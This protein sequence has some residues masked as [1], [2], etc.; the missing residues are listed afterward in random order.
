MA[1]GGLGDLEGGGAE[2]R[3]LF[4][5]DNHGDDEVTV[6]HLEKVAGV[7]GGL[8][9]FGKK[10]GVVGGDAERDSRADVA[11]DGVAD[12]VGHLGN[13]LVGD[14]EIEAVFARLTKNNGEGVGGEVLEL[15]NIEVEGATV[16]DIRNIGAGHGGEL[17][18]SDEEGAED[19][20]V[21][22]ADE[23]FR[24]IHD[25]N[26]AFVHN[27][28]NVE[29]GV[30]LADD[31]ADDGVGGEGA[32][33]VQD[34]GDRLVDLFLV[35]L[36]EF[37][38]PE[39]EDG[40]VGAVVEGFFAEIFI[41][42]HTGDVEEGGGGAV[43][44]GEESIAQNMLEAGAPG[45]AEHTLQN[46]DDFGTDVGL[47]RGVGKFERIEGDGVGGVGGVEVDDVADAILRDKL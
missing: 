1:I 37:V 8:E 38:F 26:L 13:I 20:G 10:R 2:S 32:D 3:D 47:A 24:E 11:E 16:L 46:A 28:A 44:K 5:A 22:F 27:L 45:F 17:D 43:E 9:L 19:A 34:W 33:F 25:E 35:P 30:G 14:G 39:L 36:A 42:Q 4:A 18:L 29:A 41:G 15:V 21:V 6:V 40:D 7:E 12:G 31:V 23:T